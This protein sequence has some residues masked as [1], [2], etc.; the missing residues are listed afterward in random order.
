MRVQQMTPTR[1]RF[2]TIK[3]PLNRPV[4]HFQI[5][6]A[7]EVAHALLAAN[8]IVDESRPED[9]AQRGSCRGHLTRSRRDAGTTSTCAI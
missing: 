6:P 4:N 3:S 9:F 2:A 7:L 5:A 1:G 8:E